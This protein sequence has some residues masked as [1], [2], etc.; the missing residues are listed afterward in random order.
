MMMLACLNTA[1]SAYHGDT[2]MKDYEWNAACRLVD[3][4]RT[5]TLHSY[6]IIDLAISSLQ[7]GTELLKR[8]TG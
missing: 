7:N 2:I 6:I 8:R 1:L 4:G 3:E 5:W